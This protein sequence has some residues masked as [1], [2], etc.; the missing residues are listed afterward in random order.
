MS[1]TARATLA[2]RLPPHAWFVV[3]AVF[4]YLGPSFAVL[5]FASIAPSG[6]A[7]LRIA[8][9]GLVFAIWRR[10]WR[11][12]AA[13]PRQD[14]GIVIALGVVLAVMNTVFY[15]A[16]ARLPLATVGAIE[17]LGPITVAA[18]GARTRRNLGALGLAVA[19]VYILTDVRLAGEALGYAFA[20]AN[21]GLFV[22]YITLCS[23]IAWPHRAPASIAWPPPCSSPPHSRP[24]SV[25]RCLPSATRCCSRRPL[26]LAYRPR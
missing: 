1:A 21:C 23:A 11:F 6:V 19:G 2:E 13:L 10:P 4:H 24:A 12:I 16:I 7:W 25:R 9:A 20:F 26:A 8:S 17:F 22:L 14:Q 18:W 3:S 15:E 5:L